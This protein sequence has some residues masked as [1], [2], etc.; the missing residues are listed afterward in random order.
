MA[1]GLEA[2]GAASLV[3]RLRLLGATGGGERCDFCGAP[4]PAEHRH[5]LDLTDR[6]IRCA[7]QPCHLLFLPEGAGAGRYRAVPMRIIAFP[8]G[9][10]ARWR[11]ALPGPVDLAFIFFHSA[12]ARLV[13]CYPSPHGVTESTLILDPEVSAEL[14]RLLEADVE[15][16]LFVPGGA[17]ADCFLVPIDSCYELVGRLRRF[18]RGL[19]S[20]L[21]QEEIER[22][23]M[24]LRQ[25]AKLWEG[26]G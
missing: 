1:V 5:V 25:T 3:R 11:E 23:V 4:L 8:P 20:G 17:T 10:S 15:A 19:D 26:V 6:Q 24:H 14:E 7:C 18:A 2:G 16:L 22:F 21:M 13:L 9:R 12:A